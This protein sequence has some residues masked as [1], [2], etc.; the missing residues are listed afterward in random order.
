MKKRQITIQ[1]CV[2]HDENVV[3]RNSRDG[4]NVVV[5]CNNRRSG[6]HLIFV[7]NRDKRRLRKFLLSITAQDG[8]KGIK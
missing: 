2:L 5:T 8:V 1:D 6:R 3:I 4:L 7:S